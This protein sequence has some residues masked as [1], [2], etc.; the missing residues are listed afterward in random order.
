MYRTPKSKLKFLKGNWELSANPDTSGT[1]Y[2]RFD[3]TG[4]S[5]VS[6]SSCYLQQEEGR[7]RYP[8]DRHPTPDVPARGDHASNDLVT[9]PPTP[10]DITGVQRS[11]CTSYPAPNYD[12]GPYSDLFL[13]ALSMG[14]YRSRS[15]LWWSQVFRVPPGATENRPVS[16]LW[17]GVVGPWPVPGVGKQ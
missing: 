6:T 3:K 4:D 16:D 11:E 10:S 8:Y 13:G 15:R 1:F 5:S 17:Q 9:H 14:V 7:A 2:W 12:P